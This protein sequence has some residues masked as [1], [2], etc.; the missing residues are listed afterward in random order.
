[1]IVA[2]MSPERVRAMLRKIV[3]QLSIQQRLKLMRELAEADARDASGGGL[4][5]PGRGPGKGSP[6]QRAKVRC[7]SASSFWAS[8]M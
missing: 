1:M 2:R 6:R 8:S 3:P 5:P 4:P 7:A